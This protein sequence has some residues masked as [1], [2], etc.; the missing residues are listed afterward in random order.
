MS[1]APRVRHRKEE[2]LSRSLAEHAA[3]DAVI[4]GL[5][6]E[7]W[8]LLVPRAPGKDPWT[9]RD[10]VAHIVFWKSQAARVMRGERPPEALRGQSYR[11]LNAMVYE[12]WKR[13]PPEAI[14]AWHDRVQREVLAAID[15]RDE[16]WFS[17]RLRSPF[18]PTDLES[19]SAEHR[20][21]DVQAAL[22]RSRRWRAASASEALSTSV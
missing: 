11:A 1:A 10:A 22:V 15:G 9:V 8:D 5:T 21:G 3:L 18:W 17:G 20:V 2:V 12:D 14:L 6:P 13:E 16:A 7:Q 4:R 19:H